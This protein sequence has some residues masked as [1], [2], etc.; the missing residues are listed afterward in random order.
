MNIILV[1]F[2]FL[3]VIFMQFKVPRNDKKKKH[4]KCPKFDDSDDDN[5][6]N[7]SNAVF[8]RQSSSSCCSEDESNASLEMNGTTSC[9]SSKGS[10]GLNSSGKTRASRGSATDPQSLYARVRIHF[11]SRNKQKIKTAIRNNIVS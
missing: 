9:S 4:S 8:H 11:Y 1:C 10:R 7:N 2:D 5:N 6:N 3:F